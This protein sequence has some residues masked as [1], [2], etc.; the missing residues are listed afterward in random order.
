MGGAGGGDARRERRRARRKR[1]RFAYSLPSR[2]SV[3]FGMSL[4]YKDSAPLYLYVDQEHCED[5]ATFMVF[6]RYIHSSCHA[7]G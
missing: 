7:P 6:D 2:C 3:A 1:T 5:A 4:F